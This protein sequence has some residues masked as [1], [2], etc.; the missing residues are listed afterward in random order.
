MKG[1]PRPNQIMKNGVR[2]RSFIKGLGVAG[3]ALFPAR[4]LLVNNANAMPLR[5]FSFYN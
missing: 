1:Q 2:R 3:A 5:E 4:T